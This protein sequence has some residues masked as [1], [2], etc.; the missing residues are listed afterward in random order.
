[1]TFSV[2]FFLGRSAIWAPVFLPMAKIYEE[3]GEANEAKQNS[4]A[5]LFCKRAKEAA[6]LPIS[7][8]LR[9]ENN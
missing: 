8:P 3:F 9:Q 6:L 4:V 2:I 1:M 5:I 7:P